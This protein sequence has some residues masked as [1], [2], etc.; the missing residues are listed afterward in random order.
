MFK[1]LPCNVGDAGSVP[2]GETKT[3]HALEQLSL[4]AA[5]TE[6]VLS[7]ACTAQLESLC[8]IMKD[9]TCCN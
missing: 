7:R 8:S 3:P 9:P 4:R 2:G 5:T 6:P 1:S